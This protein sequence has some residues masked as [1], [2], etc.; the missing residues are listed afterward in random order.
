MFLVFSG[1]ISQSFAPR[2]ETVSPPY[3]HDLIVCLSM[4]LLF[5][6][7][8]EWSLNLEISVIISGA[9]LLFTLNIFVNIS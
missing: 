4:Q 9:T 1:R 6:K 5:L 2:F 8:Y 3:L 7:F